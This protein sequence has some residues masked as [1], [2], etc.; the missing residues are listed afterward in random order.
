MRPFIRHKPLSIRGLQ[1]CRL[2]E[3][4]LTLHIPQFIIDVFSQ[5]FALDAPYDKRDTLV[6]LPRVSSG[7][8]VSLSVWTK[9][10]ITK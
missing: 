1:R 7:N 8:L 9:G 6:R 2:G 3:K 5:C 4:S 10:S